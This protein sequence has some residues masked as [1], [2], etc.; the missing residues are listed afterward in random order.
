MHEFYLLSLTVELIVQRAK[1]IRFKEPLAARYLI[2]LSA[3][4]NN[5][6]FS[7]IQHFIVYHR[8]FKEALVI[9]MKPPSS[10]KRSVYHKMVFII[11]HIFFT[12]AIIERELS[13]QYIVH[14]N[15]SPFISP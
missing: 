4:F 8:N 7:G 15:F 6:L 9:I 3:P 13:A 10:L 5:L 12:A 14:E 11:A 2:M 1:I